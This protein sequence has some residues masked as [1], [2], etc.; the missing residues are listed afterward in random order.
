MADLRD[1]LGWIPEP[2]PIRALEFPKRFAR[3]SMGAAIPSAPFRP[4]ISYRTPILDQIGPSCTGYSLK[5]KLMGEPVRTNRGLSGLEIYH[6][7]NATDEWSPAPHDGSS[8][9]AAMDVAL[10]E[11]L[12]ASYVWA[13]GIHD[14]VQFLGRGGG[15]VIVGSAW[16]EGM[17]DPDPTTGLI[18]PT[19]RVAGGHAYCVRRLDMKRGLGWIAQTWGRGWGLNGYAA[20]QLEDLERLAFDWGGEAAT[21]LEVRRGVHHA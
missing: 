16:T 7:A 17:F 21:A 2:D 3:F 12:I 14:I 9:R 1:K 5:T 18:R 13:E 10:E 15:P 11:G 6:R 4:R 8:V 19:G 20:I